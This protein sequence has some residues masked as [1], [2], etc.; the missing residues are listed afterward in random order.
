MDSSKKA[1]EPNLEAIQ[2]RID[3]LSAEI[4]GLR[5]ERTITVNRILAERSERPLSQADF[6]V[7]LIVFNNVMK[8]HAEHITEM[9]EALQKGASE[10]EMKYQ[11]QMFDV[12]NETMEP[13]TIVSEFL[14]VAWL[15]HPRL[16]DEDFDVIT[17][18]ND[19]EGELDGLQTLRAKLVRAQRL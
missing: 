10:A 18:A 17:R 15:L 7:A 4:D 12:L 19:A 16:G 6:I 1:D 14:N 5:A 8:S 2:A 11:R 3:K 13:T 9:L